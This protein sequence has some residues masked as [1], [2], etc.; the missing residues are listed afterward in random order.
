[1]KFIGAA[2]AETA[3]LD[4]F[5]K[6]AVK[7]SAVTTVVLIAT[8]VLQILAPSLVAGWYRTLFFKVSVPHLVCWALV[9]VP[10]VLITLYR[11]FTLASKYK[12]R[13]NAATPFGD[14]IF[15]TFMMQGAMAK[16]LKDGAPERVLCQ[17]LVQAGITGVVEEVACRHLFVLPLAIIAVF[18]PALYTDGT[19]TWFTM[20]VTSMIFTM[21]HSRST[22]FEY[23]YR[24]YAGIVL[25]NVYM[26]YGLLAAIVLHIGHN[27]ASSLSSYIAKKVEARR[28]DAGTG[29]YRL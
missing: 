22:L 7:W 24:F 15:S 28:L 17:S 29:I 13:Y 1:M 20:F 16:R 2:L 5:G 6:S 14:H 18:A 11:V 26:Y 9:L 23:G 4:T 10:P 21:L 25:F 3:W 12:A 8:M 27:A 19:L